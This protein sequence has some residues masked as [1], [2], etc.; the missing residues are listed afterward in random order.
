[1]EKHHNMRWIVGLFVIAGLVL[2]T[3]AIY[4]LGKQRNIFGASFRLNCIFKNVSGLQVGNNVRFAGINVGT[5]ENISILSDTTV[6]VK[7]V[8]DKNVKKYIKRDAQAII[9]SEGLM[10]DKIVN[11]FPGNFSSPVVENNGFIN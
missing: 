1:M 10:G 5:V 6:R 7:M 3:L 2:F 8:I 9:G 11:I 4:M